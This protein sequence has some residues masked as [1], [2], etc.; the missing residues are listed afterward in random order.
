MVETAVCLCYDISVKVVYSLNILY[1]R[2][3]KGGI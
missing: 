3:F 2:D 1:I